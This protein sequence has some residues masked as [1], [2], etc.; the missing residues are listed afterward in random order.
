VAAFDAIFDRLNAPGVAIDQVLL[1]STPAQAVSEQGRVLATRSDFEAGML[2]Q[3]K[4][5]VRR[6]MRAF[7]RSEHMPAN[8]GNQNKKLRIDTSLGDREVTRRLRVVPLQA[9][10]AAKTATV[11]SAETVAVELLPAHR[12]RQVQAVH[13]QR[14]LERLDGGDPAAAFGASRDYDARTSDGRAYAPKKVFGLALEEALGIEARPGHFHAGWDTPCFD[15]LEESGLWIAPKR[16]GAGKPRPTAAQREGAGAE[17]IATEEERAWIEGNPKIAYHLRRERQPGLAAKKRAEFIGLH[18]KLKCERCGMDPMEE[19]GEEAGHA[20]I[21]VHHHR[22]QVA[23][24]QT[25]HETKLGDLK[26]LCANC[27]RVLH[28]ALALGLP[29]DL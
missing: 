19:Y 1:D 17:I 18:G 14:A 16:T 15:I 8:E 29:F 27:H 22:T 26:C 13:I 21:E 20:C 25:G 3:V 10:G 4:D 2:H 28:R 9:T 7:G 23:A 5:Q 24:M 12:L 11:N 6:R